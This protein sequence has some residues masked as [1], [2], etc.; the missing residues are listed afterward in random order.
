ML[1]PSG[2][3]RAR[4]Q[5]SSTAA[6][7]PSPAAG[8]APQHSPQP[9][10]A[11]ELCLASAG[12]VPARGQQRAQ[13]TTGTGHPPDPAAA[14]F[15]ACQALHR[16]THIRS[17]TWAQPRW[18]AVHP[19]RPRGSRRGERLL[20]QW[21]PAFSIHVLMNHLTKMQPNSR[22]ICSEQ[23]G[24]VEGTAALRFPRQ[25]PSSAA[26]LLRASQDPAR[27]GR[28][29]R[30]TAQLRSPGPGGRGTEETLGAYRPA[31]GPPQT[32]TA[33][34]LHHPPLLPLAWPCTS[35]GSPD[36]VGS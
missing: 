2:Q 36:P 7:A 22:R 24:F 28:R 9:G 11:P 15:S 31:L 26:K 10:P 17:G 5:H 18:R 8:Q 20:V 1:P 30:R 27:P 4:W 19:P 16:S 23:C 33:P 21:A 29:A 6:P 12:S 34:S 14:A 35:H 13:A 25:D 32:P 3:C